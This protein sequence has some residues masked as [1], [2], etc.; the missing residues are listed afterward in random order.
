[1]GANLQKLVYQLN[2]FQAAEVA[3]FQ[4]AADEIEN[5][6]ELILYNLEYTFADLCFI[7]GDS[8]TYELLINKSNDPLYYF[9]RR[10]TDFSAPFKDNRVIH[11]GI[12]YDYPQPIP[13][14]IRFF[15]DLYPQIQTHIVNLAMLKTYP[16]LPKH[17]DGWI[18]PGSADTFPKDLD[19][20][21]AKDWDYEART[22][23]EHL[24]QKAIDKVLQYNMP[25]FG[26]CGGA[27]HLVLNQAGLLKPVKGF[28]D[29]FNLVAYK[30]FTLSTFLALTEFE[31]KEALLNC[32]MPKI[33]LK[34]QTWNHYAAI[35]NQLGSSIKLGAC[36]A[37]DESIAMA[38]HR[39]GGLQFATQYHIEVLYNND[40][41]Q[42][43]I[44]KS[45]L[46][47]VELYHNARLY[48]DQ[49][50]PQELYPYIE[51]RLNE[52]L[53]SPTCIDHHQD[54]PFLLHN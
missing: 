19:S 3:I 2:K 47:L 22:D 28:E 44:F 4:A 37:V 46:E 30:D 39:K 52:C 49:P 38:Y 25:Y 34:T 45:Y 6:D 35:V 53:D 32:T 27:Q 36:A 41:R 16:D 50:D 42:F 51:A 8:A 26:I 13:I 43:Q 29:A 10:N 1:M 14:F 5:I 21:S 17:F 24:Y 15:K 11:I 18:N 48:G 9:F 12:S 40:A 23:F 31:K 54:W 20:F 33:S 7:Y